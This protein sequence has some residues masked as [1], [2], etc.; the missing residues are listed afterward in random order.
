MYI[1]VIMYRDEESIHDIFYVFYKSI[2]VFNNLG[3][4]GAWAPGT[5]TFTLQT[6]YKPQKTIKV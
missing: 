4:G 2:A 5:F 6:L 1:S 3:G